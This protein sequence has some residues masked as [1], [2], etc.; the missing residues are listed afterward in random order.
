M[1]LNENI[2]VVIFYPR[3]GLKEGDLITGKGNSGCIS[4]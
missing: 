4:L 2:D 3:Y 1:L